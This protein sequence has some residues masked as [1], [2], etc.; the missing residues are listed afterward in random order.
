MRPLLP[1]AALA[2][3]LAVGPAASAQ[4]QAQ[5]SLAITGLSATS[6]NETVAVLPFQVE[7]SLSRFPCAGE[8]AE[9]HVA[10]TAA[11]SPEGNATATV[12]P[13]TLTFT[14]PP[15]QGVSGYSQTQSAL[16]TLRPATAGAGNYTA[17]VHAELDGVSGCTMATAEGS[18]TDAEAPV[19]FLAPR[20]AAVSPEGPAA[21]A[22]GLALLAL[23]LVAAAVARRLA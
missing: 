19:A 16:V 7:F 23:A 4:V 5:S 13:D 3:L 22:P 15:T 1:L 14:V 17:K 12:Q 10:L 20:G 8:G 18:G 11:A 9:I 6:T 2:V 21:P